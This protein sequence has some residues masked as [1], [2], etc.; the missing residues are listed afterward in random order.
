[1]MLIKSVTTTFEGSES[2]E[3]WSPFNTPPDSEHPIPVG[4]SPVEHK[5][6]HTIPSI[7]VEPPSQ[8]KPPLGDASLKRQGSFGVV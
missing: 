1:M 6:V 3:K 4:R 8:Q 7:V 5:P 2:T